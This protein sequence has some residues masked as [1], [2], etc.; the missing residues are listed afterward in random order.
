MKWSANPKYNMEIFKN[1]MAGVFLKSG[2][3]V[4]KI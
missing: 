3:E 4:Q 1:E 2:A